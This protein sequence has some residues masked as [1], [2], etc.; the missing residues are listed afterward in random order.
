VPLTKIVKTKGKKFVEEYEFK[1]RCE[2]AMKQRQ[3]YSSQKCSKPN[4]VPLIIE[5]H[6]K[7]LLPEL[8][9]NR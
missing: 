6:P 9:K 3:K 2:K 1:D 4:N 7:S 8:E 5:K